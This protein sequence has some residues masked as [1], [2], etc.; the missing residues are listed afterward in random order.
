MNVAGHAVWFPHFTPKSLDHLDFVHHLL[1]T[2]CE[3]DIC[4]AITGTYPAYIAGVLTSYYRT[5]PV[6][7]TLCIA[8]TLSTILDN[9]Y[10]KVDT[11]VIGPFQFHLTE[12]EK[13]EAFPDVSNYD[14]TFENVTVCFS[15]PIVNVSPSC[16]SKSSINLTNFIGNT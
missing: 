15:V 4:C 10:R 8:R 9:V 13:Y 12:R 14:I 7:R 5:Q 11:F 16:G 3:L 2:Y 1:R 6:I